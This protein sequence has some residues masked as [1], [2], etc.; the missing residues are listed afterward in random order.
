MLD[1]ELLPRRL[2]IGAREELRQSGCPDSTPPHSPES[3]L[4]QSSR[5]SVISDSSYGMD[6]GASRENSYRIEPT[7][8]RGG[9][10]RKL[11]FL[12]RQAGTHRLTGRR[13]EGLSQDHQLATEQLKVC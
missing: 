13:I 2:N 12:V 3:K 4:S 9:V 10:W 11:V 1:N 8:A 7:N 5:D 6:T